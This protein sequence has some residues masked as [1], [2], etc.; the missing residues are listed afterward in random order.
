MKEKING[1]FN[2]KKFYKTLFVLALPIIVQNLLMSSLSMVDT[3][4]VGALGDIPVAAVGIGNQVNFL[5]QLF[6]FGIT[7]GSAIFISQF[8][9]K[10][11]L[12]NIKKTVGLSVISVVI[13]GILATFIVFIGVEG[14]AKLFSSDA[15]LLKEVHSYLRIMT[16]SYI[17][18]GATI[19]LAYSLRSIEDTKTPMIISAISI[20]TNVVL[21]YCLIFGNFGMPQLGVAGAAIATVIARY[22]EF[23]LLFITARRNEALKGSFKKF[24][25]FDFIF[26][27]T[28]Y[29]KITPVMLNEISWGCGNFLYSVAYGQIG[30]SAMAAVQIC[31]NV[32]NIFVVFCM[33]MASAALVM[34]GKQ[35][36]ASNEKEAKVYGQRFI[37]IALVSGLIISMGVIIFDEM[38]I[39]MFNVSSEVKKY[40]LLILKVFVFMAPFRMINLVSIVGVLRGA[41]D[42]K[43]CLK[44]ETIGMWLI[45]VPLAFIGAVVLKLEVH[46]VM[47]IVSLEEIVKLTFCM[48]RFKGGKWIQSVIKDIK[49]DKV[50]EVNS[51]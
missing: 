44:I 51:I 9:G 33:S 46:Q 31:N 4:M 3:M 1:F 38:I 15:N 7:G 17:V 47:M 32:Q 23:I 27:K 36:G 2:D 39:G 8:W 21:N 5:V 14:I 16:T 37:V 34:I 22:T 43:Y 6:M 30:T 13:V 11:D 41:G 42:A 49:S 12:D 19:S 25:D 24:I 28:I 50:L 18:N 26:V 40:S 29:W 10:K 20:L 48:F 35:I 45:G